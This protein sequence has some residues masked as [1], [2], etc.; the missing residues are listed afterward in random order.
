MSSLPEG[1]IVKRVEGPVPKNTSKLRSRLARVCSLPEPF[2]KW[3]ISSAVDLACRTADGARLIFATMSPFESAEV[4]G[5]LSRKLG[6]PWVADL[7]DPWALDE[8]QVY[9]T[10][11]HRKLEMARMQR[12]LSSASAIV[13][14]T[15]DATAALK[16][17]FPQLRNKNLLTITNGYDSEDFA[18]DLAPRTD[19]KFRIVH[20][21][22][23]QT[24][25]GQRVR[26]VRLYHLLRGAVAGVDIL[27]RSHVMLIEALKRWCNEHP[28]LRAHLEVVFVGE[29]TPESLMVVKNAGL[30]DVV[31]FAGYLPHRESLQLVRGADLLF[32]PMH[33]LPPGQRCLIVPG[34]TYEYMASGRPI[35]AAVPDGDARDFLNRCGTALV[36]R[37]DDVAG[38]MQYLEQAY[39]AWRSGQAIGSLRQD[40]VDQFERHRLT[41][42]LASA[43]R[44][45]LPAGLGGANGQSSVALQGRM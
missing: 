36:C 12:L 25:L 3:W 39:R 23:L 41:S 5:A 44:M 26:E 13:M 33:N 21:G 24:A 17:T 42:H 45:L 14:N 16:E 34:K 38:M 32:L 31:R 40:F 20:A 9:P 2:A 19:A 28:Q 1:V 37:P 6:I 7:R 35:L 43:F 8:M 18:E 27:T 29:E 30:S 11:L 4:A 22:Y 15:P 10:L